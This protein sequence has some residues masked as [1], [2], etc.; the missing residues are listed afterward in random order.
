MC[1][2]PRFKEERLYFVY[3]NL[4]ATDNLNSINPDHSQKKGGCLRSCFHTNHPN[5]RYAPNLPLKRIMIAAAAYSAAARHLLQEK[6]ASHRR[7]NHL[8][9]AYRLPLGKTYPN[10][11]AKPTASAKPS[12]VGQ[13]AESSS[14]CSRY[15]R[16]HPIWSGFLWTV[17]ISASANPAQGYKAVLTKRR[18]KASAA[19]PPRYIGNR[20]HNQR[21]NGCPP[22]CRKRWICGKRKWFVQIVVTMVTRC[23]NRY[24]RHPGN[25]TSLTTKRTGER[26][27]RYGLVFL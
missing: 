15:W 27:T 4:G 3:E 16:T 13:S 18:A 5:S 12:A 2:R 23:A 9:S 1:G 11:S 20:R 19:T 7:R 17:A 14:N 25:R 10:T 22:N 6:P 8:P 21:H 24:G 26:K